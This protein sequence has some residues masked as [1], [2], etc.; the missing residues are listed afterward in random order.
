MAACL[1]L[2]I[3]EQSVVHQRLGGELTALV[4]EQFVPLAPR[5]RHAA[6]LDDAAALEE[7][8]VAGEVIA[9][10]LARPAAQELPSVRSGA[11][12]GEVIYHDRQR[13]ELSAPVAP[14]V[15]A[16]S[17]PQAGPE[18]RHRGLVGV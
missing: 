11:C 14:E 18:H 4:L 9:D 7:R 2:D 3:I 15:G 13:L 17:F 12:L 5:V 10:E 8:L 1:G 16:M 6:N